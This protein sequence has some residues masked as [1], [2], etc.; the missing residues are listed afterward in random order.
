MSAGRNGV[1]RAV[2]W[3]HPA[4][5]YLDAGHTCPSLLCAADPVLGCPIQRRFF[6]KVLVGVKRALFQKRVSCVGSGAKLLTIYT[7]PRKRGSVF[8]FIRA[9][10]VSAHL[11]GGE[12]PSHTRTPKPHFIR[13]GEPLHAEVFAPPPHILGCHVY[14]LF[15]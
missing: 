14:L 15:S 8:F 9:D 12:N 7:F 5:A 3:P 11:N 4:A 13:F 6:M 2:Q 10:Y 1:C